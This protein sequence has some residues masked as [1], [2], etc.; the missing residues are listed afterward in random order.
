[1]M[2]TKRTHN[3]T[4]VEQKNQKVVEKEEKEVQKKK[5]NK[6]LIAHRSLAPAP[7]ASNV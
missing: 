6:E 7:H 1:M 3:T 4:K 5:V 2:M